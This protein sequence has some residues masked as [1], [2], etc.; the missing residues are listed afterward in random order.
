M[1]DKK[2]EYGEWEH[3]FSKLIEEC[4]DGYVFDHGVWRDELYAYIHDN[5]TPNTEVQKAVE[6]IINII[7]KYKEDEL[8]GDYS[9]VH[10]A[11]NET[12]RK[13]I[14]EIINDIN[15]KYYNNK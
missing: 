9:D 7:T 15:K 3:G 8:R 4:S 5:F 2:I 10:F 14:D 1:T 13:L 6:D 11:E 12:N